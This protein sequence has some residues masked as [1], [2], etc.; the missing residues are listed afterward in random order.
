MNQTDRPLDVVI[1]AAGQGTRMKSNLPKVLHEIAGRSMVAWS[2]KAAKD[3]GA[4]QIVV[5]TRHKAEQ[6]EHSLA[7]QQLTFARQDDKAGT[8]RAFQC[9]VQALQNADQADVLVLYG[10]TPLLTTETLQAML[11]S[12]RKTQNAMTVLT[13]K[14][15]DAS[16][17]GRIVRDDKGEV[18]RIVEQK[19]ANE[20]ERAITEFNSGVYLFDHQAQGLAEQITNNN[21]AKEYYLTDLLTLYRIQKAKVSAFC[22]DGKA[23]AE[24][25]QGANDRKGLAELESIMRRRINTQHMKDGVT[26][27]DPSTT[28]IQDSVSIAADVTLEA[29]VVLKGNSSIATNTVVGAY[30]I[31]SDSIIAENAYIKPHSVLE[32]A[33]VGEASHVGPF[34]RLRAGTQLAD[35]VHVGNFVEIKNSELQQGVKAGHL[36]YLGDA[37]IG[38]ESNIGAGTIIANFDGINKHRTEIGAGVFIGSNTV[39]MAPRKIGD[40]AFVAGGSAVHKDVP[41][42]AM[43]VARGQQRNIEGWSQRYWHKFS[44]KVTQKLP[45]LA[46]WLKQQEASNSQAD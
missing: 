42:G 30:S 22:L 17:Y 40:A 35:K 41:A 24:E 33:R 26:M 29:G 8:G 6:V 44:D 3:L 39:I 38:Q 5:V 14:L 25:V 19:D 9:G 1:L 34:A 10:D 7:N 43:A 32:G 20:T 18:V 23:G 45:W 13:A 4:R 27:L 11:E 12:H 2:V 15:P 28:Y 37:T 16:G 46:E 36:T 21:K 31:I